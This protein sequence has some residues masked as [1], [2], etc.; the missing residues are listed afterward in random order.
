MAN[1]VFI[2]TSIDGYIA[3][4]DGSIDWLTGHEDPTGGEYGYG[5]FIESIDAIVI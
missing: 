3:R 5:A 4:S 1:Y 2:A